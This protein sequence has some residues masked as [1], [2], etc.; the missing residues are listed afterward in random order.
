M[1]RHSLPRS[2]GVAVF[3]LAAALAAA[4]DAYQSGQRA[5]DR[6]DWKAAAEL[7]AEAA[8]SGG[9]RA[10]AA[11]YWRGY[12]LH[13]G[14]RP[15]EALEALADLRRGFPQSDWL[16]DA[17]A[18]ELEIRPANGAAGDFE[19]EELRLYAVS[20]LMNADP[21]RAVPILERLLRRDESPELKDR[22]LFVLSQSRSRRA[23]ELLAAVA[24]GELEPELRRRAIEYLGVAGGEENAKLLAAIYAAEADV[25]VKEQVL[26]SFMIAGRK[27]EVLAA[28]RG[29]RDARLRGKA[30]ELLGVMGAREE[31]HELYRAESGTAA[32]RRV[33][34]AASIAGD[35]DFLAGVARQESDRELRRKAIQGLGITSRGRAGAVLVEVYRAAGADRE[36]KGAVL[37]ALFVQGNARSLIELARGETDRELRRE[38]LQKLSIMGTPEALDFLLEALE[39]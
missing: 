23:R 32:R 13:K 26:Q 37:D 35:V 7:F 12:A 25:E 22:A 24:R 8:E 11:L 29:E 33:L 36:T 27:A 19:D 38:A 18:L 1:K 39:D 4:Q 28:A 2:L 20:A 3:A 6:Q 21:E 17:R 5:L 16:D 15:A 31:L 34:E 9:E 10:D 14:G 30:I